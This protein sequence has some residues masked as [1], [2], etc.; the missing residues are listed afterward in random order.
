M[1]PDGGSLIS[2]CRPT[3]KPRFRFSG[4]LVGRVRSITAT[5]RSRTAF[6]TILPKI[7]LLRTAID[8][9][10]S[11]GTSSFSGQAAVYSRAKATYADVN[12]S[13]LI[14]TQYD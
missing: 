1:Q 10:R 14:Q 12:Y 2:L 3:T 7:A 8:A 6:R 9:W 13:M 5:V 11:I 4:V